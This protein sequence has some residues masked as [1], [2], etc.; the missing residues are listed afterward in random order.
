MRKLPGLL[1]NLAISMRWVG[2]AAGLQADFPAAAL[3]RFSNWSRSFRRRASEMPMPAMGAL[4][5]CKNP[6]C[7]AIWMLRLTNQ[8]IARRPGVRLRLPQDRL[9]WPRRRHEPLAEG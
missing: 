3:R 1:P 8:G 2:R 5:R 9:A 7:D 6:C 4:L